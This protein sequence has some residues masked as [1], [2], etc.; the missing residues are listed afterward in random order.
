[1]T[2]EG[3]C[4]RGPEDGGEQ[5]LQVQLGEEPSSTGQRRATVLGRPTAD[6]SPHLLAM[7]TPVA[8]GSLGAGAEPVDDG[9]SR[10]RVGL[11][12]L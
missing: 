1:M 10:P 8:S 4:R 2:R 9:G 11:S 3:G 7:D 5:Q 6:P 12:R